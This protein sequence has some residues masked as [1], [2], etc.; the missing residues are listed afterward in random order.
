MVVAHHGSAVLG[1]DGAAGDGRAV[2]VL[3][4]VAPGVHLVN[5]AAGN[6]QLAV[7]VVLDGDLAAGEGAALNHELG[8]RLA[9]DIALGHA[10]AAVVPAIC[11]QARV[12]ARVRVGELHDRAVLD[13]HS[14]EV[15]EHV[16]GVITAVVRAH[17]VL[18]RARVAATIEHHGAVSAVE[19]RRLAVAHVVHGA[20]LAVGG[21]RDGQRA[22]VGNGVAG[23]IG[24]LL[25]REVERHRLAG[26]NHDV[27]GG[28]LK[29]PDGTLLRILR[30]KRLVD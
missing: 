16:V 15:L 2:V 19:D 29:K 3:H 6:G 26:R 1:R 5:R 10:V 14:A 17:A 9:V 13:R 18:G 8:D 11:D 20:G 30:L 23:D 12:Q 24:E 25:A 21:I 22:V 4:G 27:L 28:V 7:V